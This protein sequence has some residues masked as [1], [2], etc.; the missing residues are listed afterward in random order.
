MFYEMAFGPRNGTALAKRQFMFNGE[1]SLINF[2]N[3]VQDY[4]GVVN[5]LI[6]CSMK[7]RWQERHERYVL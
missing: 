3:R 5:L 2:R 7:C 1:S 6:P 4:I